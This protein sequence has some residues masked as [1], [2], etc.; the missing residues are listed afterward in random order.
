LSNHCIDCNKLVSLVLGGEPKTS[1]EV[2]GVEVIGQVRLVLICAD[3][4]RE[5]LESYALVSQDVSHF[6]HW[7]EGCSTGILDIPDEPEVEADDYYDGSGRSAKHF[8]RAT[9]SAMVVC[10][11]CRAEMHVSIEAIAQANQFE[12]C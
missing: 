1:L 2:N 11:A 10:E 3:C 7:K 9:V 5:L 12:E 6:E 8:Y 4:G